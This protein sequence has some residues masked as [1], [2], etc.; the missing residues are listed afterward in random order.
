MGTGKQYLLL[1]VAWGQS[2]RRRQEDPR[3]HPNT[4]LP[5]TQSG[6]LRAVL[7]PPDL[8]AQS[9]LPPARA[10]SLGSL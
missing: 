3:A 5:E 9:P 10:S 1:C 2:P 6:P 7:P 4:E 8:A